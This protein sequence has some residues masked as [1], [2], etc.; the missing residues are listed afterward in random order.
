[1]EQALCKVVECYPA[2]EDGLNCVR[3]IAFAFLQ[4]GIKHGWLILRQIR[5]YTANKIEV[6][7]S[8]LVSAAR[9]EMFPR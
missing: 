1:M 2:R 9:K 4:A 8:K 3:H 5:S 7:L 6:C